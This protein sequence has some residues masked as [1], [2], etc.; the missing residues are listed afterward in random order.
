MQQY[1]LFNGLIISYFSIAPYQCIAMEIIDSISFSVFR[2]SLIRAYSAIS[3]YDSTLGVKDA[4]DP[5]LNNV[6]IAEKIKR[7]VTP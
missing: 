4:T 1:P 3:D 2:F 6:F 7:Q 5:T